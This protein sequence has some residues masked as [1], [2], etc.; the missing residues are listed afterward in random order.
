MNKHASGT[1]ETRN[2]KHE[3]R[4][5][6][7]MKHETRHPI[8]KASLKSLVYNNA[9]TKTHKKHKKTSR[10]HHSTTKIYQKNI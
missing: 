9:L 4:N 3:T 5:M 2:M 10:D 7:P 8:R 6:N 1:D